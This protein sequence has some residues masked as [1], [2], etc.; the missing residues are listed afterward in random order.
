MSRWE[1][2][3]PEKV[4]G[5]VIYQ[6]VL[7][8]EHLQASLPIAQPSL[9]VLR[10]LHTK[11]VPVLRTSKLKCNHHR[12]FI[13]FQDFFKFSCI[14]QLLPLACTDFIARCSSTSI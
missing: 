11:F 10:T 9:L 2:N 13:S 4:Q 6:D 7:R 1:R 12:I 14:A 8:H 5:E 3:G